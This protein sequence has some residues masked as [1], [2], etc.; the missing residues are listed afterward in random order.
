M[1]IVLIEQIKHLSENKTKFRKIKEMS[2]NWRMV[3]IVSVSALTLK[4]A[5]EQLVMLLI[6]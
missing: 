5:S 6:R 4:V 1:N 3:V 2:S